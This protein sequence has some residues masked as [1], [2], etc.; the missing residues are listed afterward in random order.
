MDGRKTVFAKAAAE[1]GFLPL[2]DDKTEADI[3]YICSPNNPTGA[4][5]NREQLG[6]WVSFALKKGALILFDSAYEA[7]VADDGLP[8]SIYSIPGAK[9][10]AIEFCSL[11][12]TAG[13]TGTR[14]GYTVVPK[15]LE[16][17]GH[18]LNKLWLRRQTTKFNGVSYVI[19]RAAAAVFSTDGQ[20]QIKE[21]IAYYRRNAKVITQALDELGIWYTGGK[22]SPYIWLKCPND[23]DSWSF[24]DLLL[25]E[26][27]IVGT[28]G[29]GFGE[30]G[31]G[32]FRL[33]A[34]SNYE[35]TC[36]AMNRLKERFKK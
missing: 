28:P 29:A 25:T 22:N 23:M 1:N 35:N 7:F 16:C 27:N 14:C 10:C 18:S 8:R 3:I 36:D 15:E 9:R 20:K 5:Y 17:D 21:N 26:V 2:P 11:S 32:F 6:A 13:F 31:E 30:N 19:Q 34:F 12:K 4:V 24:F 33:T